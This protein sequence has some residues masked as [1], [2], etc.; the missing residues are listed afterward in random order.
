MTS[1]ARRTEKPPYRFPYTA[2]DG[3]FAEQ[4]TVCAGASQRQHQN[5]ILYAV[6]KQPVREN[7]TFPMSCPIARQFM[8]TVLIRQWFAHCQQCY[9]LP[10]QLNLQATLYSSFVVFFETGGVL[11]SIFGFSHLFRSANNS[12]RSL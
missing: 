7:V 3:L 12:S 2:A 4:I 6:N 10:Q 1:T 5:I 8:I 9:N 11:D